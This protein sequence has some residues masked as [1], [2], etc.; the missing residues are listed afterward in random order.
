MALLNNN[1]DVLKNILLGCAVGYTVYGGYTFIK[2]HKN[3]TCEEKKNTDHLSKKTIKFYV[4]GLFEYKPYKNVRINNTILD[5]IIFKGDTS[6]DVIRIDDPHN[7]TKRVVTTETINKDD[8]VLIFKNKHNKIIAIIKE[9][10]IAL[11]VLH[12]L[13]KR[14]GYNIFLNLVLIGFALS[15]KMK[16]GLHF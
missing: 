12:E 8:N 5:R 11:T 15:L 13:A 6:V 2:I 7:I 14:E 4:F 1:S 9:N 3:I 10:R 16:T